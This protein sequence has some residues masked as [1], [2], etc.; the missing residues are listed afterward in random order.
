MKSAPVRVLMPCGSLPRM[1]AADPKADHHRYLRD[2]RE[3]VL[4]KLDGLSEYDIRRPL[5]PT[6][7]N[8]LGLVKH[9]ASVELGYCGVTFGRPHPEPYPWQDWERAEPNADLYA[10]AERSHSMIIGYYAPPYNAGY[11]R[12]PSYWPQRAG[13]YRSAISERSTCGRA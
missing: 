6:G 4:C 9:L 11:L 8:L 2:A 3:A 1:T 13:E 12:L 7:T 5:T 10:T